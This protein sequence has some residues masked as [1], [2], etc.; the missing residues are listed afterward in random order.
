MCCPPVST[1]QVRR[2]ETFQHRTKST[3]TST[4]LW[5]EFR[6]LDR[7]HGVTRTRENLFCQSGF[8]WCLWVGGFW[9]FGVLAIDTHHWWKLLYFEWSPPWHL[10]ICYWHIF[11][12]SIW[13][14]F[15]QLALAWACLTQDPAKRAIH[16]NST[17][18]DLVFY[19]GYLLAFFVPM[20]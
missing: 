19:L 18:H 15:W 9:K 4:S 10:Y 6:G 16:S 3:A 17:R 2:V 11:W 13:H 5:E 8:W 20:F 7:G 12:H 1:C 14:I